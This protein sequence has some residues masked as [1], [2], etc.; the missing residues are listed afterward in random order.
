MSEIVELVTL[1]LCVVFLYAIV[2]IAERNRIDK[3]E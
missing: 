1:F 2:F 3:D